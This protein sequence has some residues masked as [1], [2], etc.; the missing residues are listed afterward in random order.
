MGHTVG[1]VALIAGGI[2]LLA[3]L[4]HLSRSVDAATLE[5]PT[6]PTRINTD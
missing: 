5:A 2:G 3:L 4:R 6:I 1:T